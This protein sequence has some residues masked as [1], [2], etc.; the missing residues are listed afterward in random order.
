MNPRYLAFLIIKKF[1]KEKRFLNLLL[2]DLLSKYRMDPRDTAFATNIAY[3]VLRH[4]EFLTYFVETIQSKLDEDLKLILMI[5]SYQFVHL[6][7]PPHAAVNETVEMSKNVNRKYAPVVNA[8]MR[9][10]VQRG[11]NIKIK[12][13][14]PEEELSI[15][16]SL[17]TWLVKK[18][19]EDWKEFNIAHEIVKNLNTELPIHL[20]FNRLKVKEENL[21]EL[22]DSI[23]EQNPKA[24]IEKGPLPHLLKAWKM[25]NPASLKAYRDGLITVQDAS[26]QQVVLLLAPK[27]LSP[28]KKERIW[29][30][31]AAPGGKTTYL[32]EL[33]DDS[34]DILATDIKESKLYL[35]T[36]NARRLGIK[37]IKVKRLDATE[38]KPEDIFDRIL[39]D[40]PCSSIGTLPRHPEEKFLKNLSQIKKAAHLQA[41]LLNSASESLKSG[42]Y[43][44]Y[45]VCT[46][47]KEETIEIVGN[48]LKEHPEFEAVDITLNENISK[49][50][51]IGKILENPSHEFP[52]FKFW[53]NH[54]PEGEGFFAV[55]LKKKL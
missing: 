6:K 8:L 19:F 15:K 55:L 11:K 1:F 23:K 13:S 4:Y 28:G 31:A 34:T 22:I 41:K 29:D 27:T 50:I 53:I 7:T 5:G 26:S 42:G 32:A 45:S 30:V 38:E 39:L 52:P 25:R 51:P 17:P 33:T 24:R 49:S 12:A 35:I 37:S 47:T 2:R 46:L 21:Q 14:S 18:I 9:K 43:L 36:E 20:R 40:A 48:F 16:Y 54:P 3:G 10:I 44:L